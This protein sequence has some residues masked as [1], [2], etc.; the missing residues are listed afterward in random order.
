MRLS[1]YQHGQ[2]LIIYLTTLFVGGSSLAL[3]ILSTG[4]PLKD[5]AKSVKVHVTDNERQRQVLD[6][7]EQWE[8]EGKEKQKVYRKQREHL[9]DLV[10]DHATNRAQFDNQLEQLLEMDTANSRRLLDIQYGLRD[11]MTESE[12]NQVLAR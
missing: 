4:K 9:L 3:G 10:K 7:L 12:W 6:L 1:R 11:N 5:L 8:D 2:I